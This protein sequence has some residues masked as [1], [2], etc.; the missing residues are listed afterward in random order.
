M[1]HTHIEVTHIDVTLPE[2]WE[3]DAIRAYLKVEINGCLV[4]EGL[5]LVACAD[6][7]IRLMW[8]ERIDRAGRRH[9]IAFAATAE[10]RFI[11]EW[12]ALRAYGDA[13]N[14]QA[15]RDGAAS[16]RRRDMKGVRDA[17]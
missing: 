13:L 14:E 16:F 9:A 6:G 1:D 15:N 4:M 17:I 5:R 11:I 10:A 8:A 7:R 3:N 12:A 2:P